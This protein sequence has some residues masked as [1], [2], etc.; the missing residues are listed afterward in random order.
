MNYVAVYHLASNTEIDTLFIEQHSA[1]LSETG[2]SSAVILMKNAGC[3]GAGRER[4]SLAS[5]ETT[6][7]IAGLSV[8]WSCTH[9][10]PT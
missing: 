1:L 9:N 4:D 2:G 10:S 6:S 8:A 3:F 7:G 5:M